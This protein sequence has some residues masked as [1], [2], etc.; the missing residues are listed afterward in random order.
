MSNN[1]GLAWI[2]CYYKGTDWRLLLF[3][4]LFLNVKLLIKTG[5][6]VLF[7]AWERNFRFGF[8]LK[9]SRL[10]LFYLLLIAIGLLNWILLRRWTNTDYLLVTA[11]GIFFWLFCIL[12]IHQVKL[13]VERNRIETLEKTVLVFFLLNAAVSLAVY[14]G[15]IIE[16]GHINPYRYQGNFQKYFIGTGDYIKGISFDTSST[17][18]VLNAA[19]V[20]WFLQ[21]QRFR[22]ALLC[23]AVLL[24][25]G[26]NITN[27]LLC[28][29]LLFIFIFQSNRNQKSIIIVCLL[30]LVVFLTKISPQNSNYLVDTWEKMLH[31]NYKRNFVQKKSIRITERPDSTLSPDEMREK[32]AQR[33]LDS[34][35]RLLLAAEEKKTGLLQMAVL[36]EK[37]IEKPLIPKDSIH[38]P[39]FQH[40]PDTTA[41]QKE[42]IAFIA[43]QANEVKMASSKQSGSRLPGKIQAYAQTLR[44]MK[45]HP[46]RIPLGCGI[47][48]FSSKLAFRA[49][50]MNIAGGYPRSRQYI[51]KDFKENHL[52]L[53]LYYFTNRD[54]L[55]SV[56]NSPNAAYDQ[57]LGEYGLA[58]LL[59]FLFSYLLFFWRRIARKSYA[60]PLLLLLLGTL[61]V[62]YW[63][64]QL[65]VVL[66]F[67]LLFFLNHKEK[68]QTQS[69]V[70]P[71]T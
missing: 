41:T 13:A 71:G 30:M 33:Y 23:M 31:G 58:G 62:E 68:E 8:R 14:L 15:I 48:N 11:T 10:P 49:T 17:N 69:H 28:A 19:G 55:H 45:Q 29:V 37:F 2:S 1:K 3:L 4:I 46:V 24:L 67:E 27:L 39:R 20:I 53:F 59:A 61:A 36:P 32:T 9:N 7:F 38:T 34:L 16:T 63:F 25:T 57:L 65:S 35:N 56:I 6:V 5:I 66:L 21:H 60:L 52:D 50:A 70:A 54:D 44:F 47:G 42:M 22:M 64:E 43:S 18:A 51:S 40:R 26:S 12:A